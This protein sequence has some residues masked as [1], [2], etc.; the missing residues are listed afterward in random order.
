MAHVLAAAFASE[1]TVQRVREELTQAPDVLAVYVATW[2]HQP[3]ATASSRW[4]PHLYPGSGYV[5]WV[6]THP[7][8]ERRGL[9]LALMSRLLQDFRE[10]DYRDAVLETDDFRLPA[11]KTY[12]RCGFLPV[13]DVSGEDHRNRWAAIFP[14]IFLPEGGG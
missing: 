2:R 11:I 4:L 3:V 5:H 7:D 13:Y 9:G 8:H 1:W 14:R 12:L 10:R 6:G